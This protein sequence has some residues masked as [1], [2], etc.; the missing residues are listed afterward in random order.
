MS[1]ITDIKERLSIDDVESYVCNF[2]GSEGCKPDGQGNLV[3]FTN[4]CHGGDSYKLYYYADSMTFFCFSHCGNIGDIF[5]LTAHV[6]GCDFN[7]AFDM[8]CSYFHLRADGL[9]SGFVPPEKPLVE[10]WGILNKIFDFAQDDEGEEVGESALPASLLELYEKGAPHV[11][12]EDGISPS[13][14]ERYDIRIDVANSKIVIPH[15]NIEGKL[16]GIRG[17]ALDQEEID[18]FGKYAPIKLGDAWMTHPLGNNLYGLYQAQE[19]IRHLRKVCIAESEKAC[20]QS[21]TMF[22]EANF[23]VATCGSS[24]LSQRQIDLLLECDV[25]EII[26][27]YDKEYHDDNEEEKKDYEE[28]L[29]KILQP[30][31]P[32]FNVCVLFDR[33]GLLKYKMSPFDAGKDVLLRLME[34]KEKINSLTNI[35]I[36]R[37]ERGK[38]GKRKK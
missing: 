20:M 34:K 21:Y 14:M 36:K 31:A 3:F 24:G 26:L 9:V 16:I 15:Y 5:D 23:T 1:K 7:E 25:N 13:A 11:W 2:L 12:I 37:R 27:A 35:D 6:R 38:N 29:L 17:R 4:V 10:D 22:G 33:E 28:K 18:I 32:L 8:V 19:N 30:L